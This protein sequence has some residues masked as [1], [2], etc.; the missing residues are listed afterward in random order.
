MEQHPVPQQISAYHFRLVGDMTLKQ[1][2]EL[3]GGIIAAWLFYSLPL[4]TIFRWPLVIF[5]VFV[6]VALAFLPLEER[7][8]DRWLIA[9]LKAIYFPTQYVW[10]KA[11]TI[12][13]VFQEIKRLGA[14][15]AIEPREFADRIKLQTYLE[16]LPTQGPQT[17]VDQ[18]EINFVSDIM[19]LY[20][21]VQPKT[22]FKPKPKE[23]IIEVK[24]PKV[25]VRKIK[26]PPID[27]RAIMRGEIIMPKRQMRKKIEIPQIEPIEVEK[28]ESAP[29]PPFTPPQPGTPPLPIGFEAVSPTSAPPT[30]LI[31]K[32]QIRTIAQASLRPELPIPAPPK[33]PNVLVGMVVDT[34][35]NIVENAIVTIRDSQGNVARAQ[36][37]NKIGQFFIVTPLKNGSHEIEVEK[38][39][40]GFDII[41]IELSGQPVPPIEIRAKT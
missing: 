21:E 37:T 27:P 38:E 29:P 1:F 33:Q 17:G 40:L 18:K 14:K 11:I 28:L 15:P 7:P 24:V 26:T 34:E 39:G 35:S 10:K 19:K 25:T 31:Q 4:P 6:G 23:E 2:A 8:L 9:F 41:N 5:A 30:P 3:A 13:A 36:K 22:V 20:G 12:P 16:S 32:G